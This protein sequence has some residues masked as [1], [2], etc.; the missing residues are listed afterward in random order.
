MSPYIV[1]TKRLDSS[2]GWADSGLRASRCAFPTLEKAQDAAWD[3]I[4]DKDAYVR[5][6]YETGVDTAIGEQ[7]GTITLPDG[8][9]IEVE[10]T[11]WQVL[12]DASGLAVPI[13]PDAW[14]EH[15]EIL[16]AYNA[17]QSEDRSAGRWCQHCQQHGS[18]HTDRHDAYNARQA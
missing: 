15:H 18:H 17:R 16:D 12:V 3:A 1:T 4:P 11:T 8:T 2:E 6:L 13:D 10:Q 5:W 14:L 9:V 7:G